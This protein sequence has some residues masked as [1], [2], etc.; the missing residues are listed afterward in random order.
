MVHLISLSQYRLS[1]MQLSSAVA[2]CCD[3]CK[4]WIHL[5]ST[6]VREV[7]FFHLSGIIFYTLYPISIHQ[8]YP[9]RMLWFILRRAPCMELRFFN[10]SWWIT[11]NSWFGRMVLFFCALGQHSRLWGQLS[12]DSHSYN[13]S[14]RPYLLYFTD[15]GRLKRNLRQLD[16]WD[17]HLYLLQSLRHD[18]D[19]PDIFCLPIL[20]CTW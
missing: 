13:S 12:Q 17:F 18:T 7:R 8:R 2:F 9:D 19:F 4:D 16:I 15:C 3:I 1:S 14:V 20:F 5:I 10:T 11:V 6:W